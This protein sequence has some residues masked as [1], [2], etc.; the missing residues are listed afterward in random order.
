MLL[1]TDNTTVAAYLNKGGGEQVSNLGFLGN[2]VASM[3]CKGT[4]VSD[5][6]IRS[7]QTEHTRKFALEEGADHSYRVDSPQ[8]HSQIFHFWEVPRIDLFATRLNNQL[9][10]FVSLFH[11]PLAWAVDAMS[12]SWEGMLAYAFPPIP[13]LLKVL[14]KMEKDLLGHSETPCL[15]SHPCFP[16]L[17]SLL[18]APAI[19][20]P[21]W[22]DLL[23]QPH[24]HLTHPKPEIFNLHA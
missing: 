7:R 8:G 17:L 23:I 20:L 5:S 6:Q 10:T 13:L 11:D 1:S 24:S 19:K 9:P 4:G 2:Q 12:L 14:L 3:V 22:R 18:V 16:V 15:E 21:C